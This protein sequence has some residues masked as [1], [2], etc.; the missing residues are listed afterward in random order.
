MLMQRCLR[1]TAT[2]TYVCFAVWVAACCAV[3]AALLPI[4][5]DALGKQPSPFRKGSG[6][7][8]SAVSE[9][10]VCKCWRCCMSVTDAAGIV[11]LDVSNSP[12]P[13]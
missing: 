8:L 11:C 10:E 5:C 6:Y 2:Q 7:A 3:T 4:T 12:L 1:M 13:T 9:A